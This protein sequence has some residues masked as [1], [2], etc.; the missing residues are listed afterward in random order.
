M[1]SLPEE[2]LYGHFVTTLN[3]AFKTKL[4]Q[5]DEGYERGSKSFNIS[6][7]L[8]RAPRDY[9]VSTMKEL[10]FN[11]TNVGQSTTSPE[12]NEE[13]SPWGYRHFSFTHCQLVFSSSDNESPVRSSR[14]YCQHPSINARSPVHRRAR[15]SLPEHQNQCH[16]CSPTPNTEQLSPDFDNLAWDNGTTPSEEDFPAAPLDDLVWSEDPV[17]D[18]YLCIQKTPH[19][20]NH[21]CSCP[22]LYR[23]TTIRME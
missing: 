3:N 19:E 17:L 22:C 16:H 18:R 11:P 9:Y 15:L 4:A 23:N 6:T 12:H 5:Q 21:Q 13:H 8:S 10:S 14:C 2:T 1:W 7:P 20:L